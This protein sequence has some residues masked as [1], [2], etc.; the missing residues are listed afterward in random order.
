[1][2]AGLVGNGEGNTS[3]SVSSSVGGNVNQHRDTHIHTLNIFGVQNPQVSSS[4][5]H[6]WAQLVE[7][8]QAWHHVDD[9]YAETLRSAAAIAAKLAAIRDT[10]EAVVSADP[11]IDRTFAERVSK[12]MGWA[13]K[14]WLAKDLRLSA[15]EAALLTLVPLVQHTLWVATAAS[16]SSVEPTTLTGHKTPSESRA[17]FEAFVSGFP[18]LVGRAELPQLPDRTSAR[19]EI[20]WWLFHHWLAKRMA[21]LQ[22]HM[23][24]DLLAEAGVHDDRMRQILDP[25]SLCEILV[26]LRLEPS[27][28]CDKTRLYKLK[29]KRPVDGGTSDEEYIRGPLLTLVLSIAQAAAIKITDLSDTVVWHLGIPSSVNLRQLH[30]S[31]TQA[32][33]EER[34]D[35]P[36]LAATCHHEAIVV[37]LR[38]YATRIDALLHAVRRAAED[39][40]ALGVLRSLPSRASADGVAPAVSADGKPVFDNWSQFRLDEQRVREL[41][42]GEQL[43]HNRDLAI[44]ELY[45]NALD[46]CRYREARDK[47]LQRKTGR[48]S[49]WIGNIEFNQDTEH[50][51]AYLE[52]AD[53]GI[54]MGH[55]ELTGVFAQAG[56]RFA[57]LTEFQLEQAN[58]NS[59]DPPIEFYPNSRFGIGV[60]SYFM[61]ADEITVTT[62]RMDSEGGTPGPELQA[63][64]S[65]PGHLFHIK[66]IA[67]HGTP[68]TQVRL[69]L[70]DTTKPPSCVRVL[71]R[72]L[73]IADFTTTARHGDDHLEW[74]PGVLHSRESQHWEKG[75][76]NAHGTLIPAIDGQV[77]WCERGGALLVDGLLVKPSHEHGIFASADFGEFNGVVVNLTGRRAPRLSVDR[78]EVLDDVS[79]TVERLL[80]PATRELIET[81]PPLADFD[82]ISK[83]GHNSPRLADL[84]TES[85][86]K[87][88]K[89]EHEQWPNAQQSGHFSE[90]AHFDTEF[91][92]HVRHKSKLWPRFEKPAGGSPPDHIFLWRVVAHRPNQAWKL[93]KNEVSDLSKVYSTLPALPSDLTLLCPEQI[94]GYWLLDT[95]LDTPGH[96]LNTAAISGRSPYETACRARQLGVSSQHAEVF[97]KKYTP[98]STEIALVNENAERSQQPLTRQYPIPVRHMVSAHFKLGL[99]FDDLLQRM[100]R[101]GFDTSISEKITCTPTPADTQLLNRRELKISTEERVSR[102]TLKL[103][104]ADLNLSESEI[105]RK[106]TGYGF[107]FIDDS[108]IDPDSLDLRLLSPTLD[109]RPPWLAANTVVPLGHIAKAARRLDLTTESVCERLTA[110]GRQTPNSVPDSISY[111][112]VKLLSVDL[113]GTRP[114]LA[115]DEAVTP[116]HLVAAWREL[117]LP[118]DV[119]AKELSLLEFDVPHYDLPERDLPTDCILLGIDTDTGIVSKASERNVPLHHLVTCALKLSWTLSAVV[120]RLRQ[121]GVDVP[122][123]KTTIRNAMERLPH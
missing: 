96:I 100:S 102:W 115:P 106:L 35:G 101:Y 86:L 48:A 90:D 7:K 51:R 21:L 64:I 78:T 114:W 104:S 54:G 47:Y 65:G 9:E 66:K 71:D 95:K 119:A 117:L 29:T 5:D 40:P 69:Y 120:D 113:D 33:W 53:N 36:V 118:P 38:E 23:I 109:G 67:E 61:L 44:R 13:L 99:S 32:T 18:R 45:Q 79:T 93:L 87:N 14:K 112:N 50:G 56:M 52:C 91:A 57:D 58:W 74:E 2:E 62:C 12:R 107:Q 10:A 41:L 26:G 37:A 15:A 46:A 8:S 85:I 77:V 73:G 59:V 31:V 81:E 94:D 92:S 25:A 110:L 20:G 49:G 60:L 88:A 83:V 80:I 19:V 22:P 39:L 72:L 30:E 16:L 55:A 4:I 82:W 116:T 84:I 89:P 34:A 68:G 103:L 63:T 108:D 76:L 11:W 70:Q 43:Y 3:N 6:P 1:M 17:E 111:T 105:E 121:L 24:G 42:M 28:L 122:D 123:I 75:G 97:S 27:A 98:D